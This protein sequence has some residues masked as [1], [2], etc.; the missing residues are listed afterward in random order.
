MPSLLIQPLV[1]NA[2]W[3]GLLHKNGDR[4]LM[5]SFSHFKKDHL[6][7]VVHDNGIGR[8]KAAEIKAGKFDSQKHESKGM[9]I[10]QERIDLVKLQTESNT[11]ILVEDLFDSSGQPAGTKVSVILPLDIS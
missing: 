5:I 9:Q 1:E 7:C 4:K 8:K 6:L 11:D 2:I 3:H 10:S